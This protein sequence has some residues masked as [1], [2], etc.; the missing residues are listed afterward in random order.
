MKKVGIVYDSIYADHNTEI[1]APHPENKDRVLHTIESLTEQDM[2]GEYRPDHFVP[3]EPREASIKEILWAHSQSLVSRVEENVTL[4][5]NRFSRA[6]MDG[7]TPVSSRSMEA[8][9]M[10]AGGNFAAI[11]AI[12]DNE[13]NSAFTLCRPPGHH[14]NVNASRGFCLFNNVILASQYLFR[15]KDLNRVAILDF[16]VHAGNGSEDI[17]WNGVPG[18]PDGEKELLFISSHQDPSMFY[19]F[20]CFVDEVGDESQKGKIVNATYAPRS[21]DMCMQMVLKNIV[22]PLFDEFKPEFLLIS[23]GFDGHYMDPI[24]GLAFTRQ[25]FGEIIKT[26]MP[27]VVESAKGRILATLEGGYNINALSDSIT[28]I[29][30]V[31]SGGENIHKDDGFSGETAKEISFTENKLIPS[32]KEILAPYWKCFKE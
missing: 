30:N 13:I 4:A 11:D 9:L 26:L 3:I 20:S 7:D 25:G 18:Y 24:G 22:R 1:F 31:L 2:Y 28:N 23:A 16:D 12:F 5:S 21:G 15:I 8:A 6:F 29:L 17:I 27:M 19:P 32:I 10:A 14:A